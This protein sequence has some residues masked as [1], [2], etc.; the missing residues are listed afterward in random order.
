M[1]ASGGGARAAADRDNVGR[2]AGEADGE[3]AQLAVE[4]EPVPDVEERRLDGGRQAEAVR[5]ERVGHL[6]EA[7]VEEEHAGR[8]EEEATDGAPRDSH[9]LL[10]EVEDLGVEVR[11][12]DGDVPAAGH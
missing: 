3:G 12:V 9:D 10:V 6:E 8:G 1:G 5:L 7:A 2:E 4:H 11:D